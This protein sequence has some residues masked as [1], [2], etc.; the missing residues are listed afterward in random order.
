[1]FELKY[2]AFTWTCEIYGQYHCFFYHNQ[3]NIFFE[4]GSG[5]IVNAA[6]PGIVSTSIK[7]HMGVDKSISGNLISKPL[8][9]LVPGA[10]KSPTE[11]AKT[12]LYLTLDQETIKKD[13]NFERMYFDPQSRS[14]YIQKSI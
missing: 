9:W 1:M 6:Y 12:P 10:G 8:L 4:I 13:V 14:K 5:T 7:R 11:G 2:T 3:Q